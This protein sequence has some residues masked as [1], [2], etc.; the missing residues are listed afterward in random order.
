MTISG[1]LLTEKQH[2]AA[3]GHTYVQEAM[4]R[5]GQRLQGLIETYTLLS[6]SHWSPSPW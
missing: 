1:L 3:E 2:A 5:L 6:N 4:E